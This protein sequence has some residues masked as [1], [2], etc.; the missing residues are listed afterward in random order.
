[1]LK[2][3]NRNLIHTIIFAML[4]II[5]ICGLYVFRKDLFYRKNLSETRALQEGYGFYDTPVS[6]GCIT[7]NNLCSE[8]GVETSVSRCIPN[9]FTNN[10]CFNEENGTMTYDSIVSSKP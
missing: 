4:S 2:S 9:P 7:E 3:D 8:Q 5:V 6:L 1:M 10:G